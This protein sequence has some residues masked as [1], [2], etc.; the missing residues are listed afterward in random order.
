M[1]TTTTQPAIDRHAFIAALFGAADCD[2][3]EQSE[4]LFTGARFQLIDRDREAILAGGAAAGFH[5]G[6]RIDKRHPRG[7]NSRTE[8]IRIGQRILCN[9][10]DQ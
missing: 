3:M 6:K 2:T 1:E 7:S 4:A 8:T 9:L 10:K 5:E